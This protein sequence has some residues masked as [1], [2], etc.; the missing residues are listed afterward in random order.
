MDFPQFQSAKW[1]IYEERYSEKTNYSKHM[2]SSVT[3]NSRLLAAASITI[4]REWIGDGDGKVGVRL[5]MQYFAK[6]VIVVADW[7]APDKHKQTW[8]HPS[9]HNSIDVTRM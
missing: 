1:D 5:Q 9:H 7:R 3:V 6:K 8:C 4:L 2:F